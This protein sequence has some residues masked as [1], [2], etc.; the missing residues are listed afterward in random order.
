MSRG[1]AILLAVA[2]GCILGLVLLVA[3]MVLVVRK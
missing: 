3:G 1:L 2:A